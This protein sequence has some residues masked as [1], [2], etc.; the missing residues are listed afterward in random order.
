MYSRRQ[1]YKPLPI[2]IKSTYLFIYLLCFAPHWCYREM[3][4]CGSYEPGTGVGVH[5]PALKQG[6]VNPGAFL[7][8]TLVTGTPPPPPPP[9]TLSP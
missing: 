9:K 3:T 6:S 7:L 2:T 4:A 1:V 5:G 8:G